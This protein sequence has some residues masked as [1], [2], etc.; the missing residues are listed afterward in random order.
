METLERRLLRRNPADSLTVAL[1]VC[2]ATTSREFVAGMAL[3]ALTKAA[4]QDD[5][6]AAAAALWVGGL[7]LDL[8][9]GSR[10]DARRRCSDFLVRL[11]AVDDAVAVGRV[12]GEFNAEVVS[13]SHGERG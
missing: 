5:D 6:D 3:L 12:I 11:S 7:L 13:S 10:E 9:L 8:G 2:N 1:R 4:V